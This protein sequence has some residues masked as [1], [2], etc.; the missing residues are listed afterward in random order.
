MEKEFSLENTAKYPTDRPSPFDILE[1]RELEE[2]G[3]EE[4][5]RKKKEKNLV[6][7]EHETRRC[8]EIRRTEYR[9]DHL[10]PVASS[11]SPS[12][13]SLFASVA[14]LASPGAGARQPRPR[15]RWRPVSRI[16]RD[17]SHNESVGN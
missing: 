11:I 13:K 4:K 14:Y 3:K 7:G 15:L 17:V 2:K 12:W 9:G 1:G 8:K 5:K 6:G 16:S 10:S